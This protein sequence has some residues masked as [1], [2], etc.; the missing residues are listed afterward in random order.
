MQVTPAELPVPEVAR[1]VYLTVLGLP[2]FSW[3]TAPFRR[4]VDAAVQVP[5]GVPT[6]VQLLSLP[7]FV[8]LIAPSC[9]VSTKSDPSAVMVVAASRVSQLSVFE[10]TIV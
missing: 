6:P 5:S 4:R 3:N 10:S 7:L 9:S 8:I 2:L 1:D